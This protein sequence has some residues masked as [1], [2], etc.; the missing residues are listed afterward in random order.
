MRHTTLV[1][2]D[3]E[4]RAGN[5]TIPHPYVMPEKVH[6]ASWPDGLDHPDVFV[7]HNHREVGRPLAKIRVRIGSTASSQL[8]P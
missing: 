4:G 3:A 5:D 2:G 6:G 8:L 7:A 1:T